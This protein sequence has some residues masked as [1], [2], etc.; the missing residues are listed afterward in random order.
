MPKSAPF[1]IEAAVAPKLP[2]DRARLE[3]ALGEL[4]KIDTHLMTGTDPES[5]QTILKSTSLEALE[6]AIDTLKADFDTGAPKVAYRETLTKSVTVRYTHKKAIGGSGEFADITIAFEPL[7]PGS[8]EMFANGLRPEHVLTNDRT[9]VEA[10]VA[11]VGKGLAAQKESGLLAGFP[12]VDF[13][14]TLIDLRYHP[15]D[16]SEHTFDTAARA[17]FRDIAKH[18]AL[19]LVEPVMKVAVVT[20]DDFLGSVIGDI[21]SRRGQMQGQDTRGNAQ[22][23]TA[24]VPLANLFY[25]A[26]DLAAISQGRASAS[27]QFHSYERV[28]VDL[29]PNDDDPRFPGAMGAR[30]A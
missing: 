14:A 16:S 29:L 30:V 5:G 7:P 19:G 9:L 8:G 23:V 27:T 11:G 22:V 2:A 17:A 3:S 21:N 12:V 20:P 6:R 13:K 24:T 10:C 28:P 15:V 26:K 1:I 18:N 25:Y 4:T